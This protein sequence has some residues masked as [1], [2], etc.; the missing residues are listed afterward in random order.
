M[1]LYQNIPCFSISPFSHV[2]LKSLKKAGYILPYFPKQYRIQAN[3]SDQKI[4]AS[5]NFMT[6]QSRGAMSYMDRWLKPHLFHQNEA[7]DQI[8]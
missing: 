3:R 8:S 1:L 6:L 7:G 5:P 4:S 2:V